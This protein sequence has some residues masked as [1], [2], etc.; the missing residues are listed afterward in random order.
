MIPLGLNEATVALGVALDG[1]S[2]IIGWAHSKI[3]GAANVK[4]FGEGE[5]SAR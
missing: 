3:A 1:W 4:G 5:R 2:A